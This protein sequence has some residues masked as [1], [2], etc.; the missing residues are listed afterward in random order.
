MPRPSMAE[1]IHVDGMQVVRL[2]NAE[3]SAEVYLYGAHVTSYVRRGVPK[4]FLSDLAALDGSAPIRGGIPVCFP[5][6]GKRGPMA[7][8]HGFARRVVWELGG[9]L[10]AATPSVVLRLPPGEH[11]DWDYRLGCLLKVALE[12]DGTLVCHMTVHNEESERACSFSTALHAYFCTPDIEKTRI[13]G[14]QGTTYIDQ[15]AGGAVVEE[16]PDKVEFL[17]EVDRI[18]S[19]V[20]SKIMIECGDNLV[21]ELELETFCD[22]I[23]WNPH[24]EKSR[25]MADLP[26]DAWK[27]FV[28]VEPAVAV[29][30][31]VLG[32][33]EHW[34]AILRIR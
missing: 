30:P 34:A 24:V 15:L 33:G 22:A 11:A 5:Q 32:A 20:P 19:G 29:Q 10:D 4:L 2:S 1:L 17:S 25:G 27:G 9:A 12:V 18:Y 31:V 6:F 8:Q 16:Y 3:A 21:S 7:V 23:V 14:L 26:D 13:S 28:C